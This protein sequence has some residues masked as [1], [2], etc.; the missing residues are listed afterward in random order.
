MVDLSHRHPARIHR[1]DLLIEAFEALLSFGDQQRLKT[2]APIPRNLDLHRSVFSKYRLRRFTPTS[3]F[4][5]AKSFSKGESWRKEVHHD[6]VGDLRFEADEAFIMLI[7]LLG[8]M[9]VQ[10]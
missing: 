7:R 5:L 6:E 10:F 3:E 2:P 9:S 4:N 1:D 8:R